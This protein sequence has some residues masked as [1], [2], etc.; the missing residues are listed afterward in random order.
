MGIDVQ[1]VDT[2]AVVRLT[3]GRANAMSGA[4]L[5]ELETTFADLARTGAPQAA[6]ERSGSQTRRSAVTTMRSNTDHAGRSRVGAIAAPSE[7]SCLRM[8]QGQEHAQRAVHARRVAVPAE[9]VEGILHVAGVRSIERDEQVTHHPAGHPPARVV[10]VLRGD[11]RRE[12]ARSAVRSTLAAGPDS[13]SSTAPTNRRAAIIPTSTS[14]PL[15]VS[16]GPR[17]NQWITASSTRPAANDSTALVRAR[18]VASA[19]QSHPSPVRA[20]VRARC[21]RSR[22]RRAVEVV[23]ARGREGGLEDHRIAGSRRSPSRPCGSRG[24][25]R[26]GA[27]PGHREASVD[28]RR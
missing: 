27:T 6:N 18:S 22:F 12:T 15:G 1:R 19:G 13:R 28:R 20:R 10:Q 3:G 7:G 26:A 17:P 8:P 9:P 5:R 21:A 24:R 11:V 23:A 16:P 25:G 2:V 4:L 14:S